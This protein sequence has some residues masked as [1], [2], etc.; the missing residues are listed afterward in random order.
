MF[1]FANVTRT[2]KPIETV[3]NNPVVIEGAEVFDILCP[4]SKLTGCRENPLSLL[5]KVLSPDK[6][7]ALEYALQEVPTVPQEGTKMSDDEYLNL[8]MPR[9]ESGSPSEDAILRSR[10]ASVID[11]IRPQL[12]SD[13]SIK[14]ES[15]DNPEVKSE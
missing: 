7:R 5:N 2:V 15:S 12:E 1:G 11:V 8:L 10:L 13:H 4:V 14:F 6:V 9:L 3:D